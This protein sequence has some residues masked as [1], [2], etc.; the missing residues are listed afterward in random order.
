MRTVAALYS[1]PRGP[2]PQ[3]EGVE[4]WGEERDAKNYA[5]PWPVVAHPPCGPW[6]RLRFLCRLQDPACGPAA[7]QSVRE[8][9]GVLEHP[10]DS[11]LWR[12]CGMPLPGWLPDEFGGRTY[13]VRQVAWGHSCE[14]PTWLYV[15]GVDPSLVLAG[16]RTG[17]VATHRVTSGPRGPQFPTATNVKRRLSPPAFAE[18][19]VE[20]ARTVSPPANGRTA[21]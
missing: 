13:A 11:L 19:L 21:S 6:G 8:F 10:V 4:C 20:L 14:K 9:G 5:G 2:Y 15:V 12:R 18:W 16:I 3:M 17:G 7:V 1:G